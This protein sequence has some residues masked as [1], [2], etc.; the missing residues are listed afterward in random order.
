MVDEERRK[1]IHAAV[2]HAFDRWAV[3]KYERVIREF[4][5]GD[6]EQRRMVAE[7]FW[8]EDT[9]LVRR[10]RDI[11]FLRHTLKDIRSNNVIAKRRKDALRACMASMTS[12][13]GTSISELVTKILE[14]R[15]SPPSSANEKIARRDLQRTLY[16]TLAESFFAYKPDDRFRTEDERVPRITSVFAPT[17]LPPTQ[18]TEEAVWMVYLERMNTLC[19]QDAARTQLVHMSLSSPLP[20][21]LQDMIDFRT[22][23]ISLLPPKSAKNE[24]AQYLESQLKEFTPL[25]LQFYWHFS[26]IVSVEY[27]RHRKKEGRKA[28]LSGI[29]PLRYDQDDVR[30][31]RTLLEKLFGSPGHAS[32]RL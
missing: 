25:F 7:D 4:G 29:Y 10:M 20:E 17:T 30:K 24:V 11:G 16:E 21:F 18:Q 3:R 31:A 27:F 28:L 23:C 22:D 1:K 9:F 2:S 32:L 19:T 5:E 8:D 13:L 6:D 26:S 14:S 12:T 15:A